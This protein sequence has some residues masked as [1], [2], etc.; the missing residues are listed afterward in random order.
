MWWCIG[1][2]VIAAVAVTVLDDGLGRLVTVAGVLA[3]M[4]FGLSGAAGYSRVEDV[5]VLK[6]PAVKRARPCQPEP[7]FAVA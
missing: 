1:F 7:S 4:G 2:V 3:A 5:R 6:Q